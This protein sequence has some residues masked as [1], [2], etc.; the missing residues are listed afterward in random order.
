MGQQAKKP[1]REALARIS[2]KVLGREAE[3]YDDF[4]FFVTEFIMT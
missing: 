3:Y 2:Q 1:F 4:Y